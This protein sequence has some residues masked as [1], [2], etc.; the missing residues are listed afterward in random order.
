MAR[1][2]SAQA[3]YY[4]PADSGYPSV[5]RVS[6]NESVDFLWMEGTWCYIRYSVSGTANKKCGYVPETAV[7]HANE[8]PLIYNDNN[9]GDR[10]IRDGGTTY[11][12]PG[13]SGYVS[14]GSVD[15][16][17]LVAY[18]GYKYND[19]AL[20]EYSVGSTSNKKRAWY[21]AGDMTTEPASSGSTFYNYTA[22]GWTVTSPWNGAADH[23]GHLGLDLK[24]PS[25]TSFYALAD[26]VV[27]AKSSSCLRSNGYTIVLQH[28]IGGKPFFSFYAHMDSSPNLSV[29]DRVT[30][31]TPIHV[32]GASGNVTG[33]HLHLGVYTGEINNDQ[34]GYYKVNDELTYFNDY[35]LGYIDYNN[36]RFFDPAQVIATNGGVIC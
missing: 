3:V 19:Y 13:S 4:G 6:A 34:Y 23:P 33:P 28:N 24:R 16:G 25:D 26:G 30:C 9:S 22:N 15:A 29:G 11:T 7:N 36:Y 10:Y 1:M 2:K 35:G 12:G 14:A 20:I 31:G 21:S 18:T 27:V 17:E 5:G 8:S 32:Y